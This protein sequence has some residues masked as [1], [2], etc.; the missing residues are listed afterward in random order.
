MTSYVLV[1]GGVTTGWYWA[2]VAEILEQEGHHV[3]VPELPSTGTEK[4]A[5]GDLQADVAATRQILENVMDPAVLV[6]HSYG[7]MIITEFAGHPNVR[8]S[9]YLAALWP[10]AG[11]SAMDLFDPL[12]A[13]LIAR[14]DGTIAVTD[15][16]DLARD[17]L[18]GDLDRE[19]AADMH[20]RLVLSSASSLAAP[21]TGPPRGH[22]TTYIICEQDNA[23]PPAAQEAMASAAD[24][25]VRLDCAHQPMLS[26][27]GELAAVL[28]RIT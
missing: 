3:E 16:F 8:H 26:M 28:G 9:V 18:G 13:W 14:G 6:G 21:S 24:H 7:G 5:L 20:S 27:P 12:P 17:A 19:R 15:D 4:E 10:Q 1:H 2:A 25:I 11:Q 23:A 22:P